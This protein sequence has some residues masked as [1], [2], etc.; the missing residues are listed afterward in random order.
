MRLQ[1]LG[2][3]SCDAAR[4]ELEKAFERFRQDTGVKAKIGKLTCERDGSEMTFKVT[5]NMDTFQQELR[6]GQE[7]RNY[8]DLFGL[9]MGDTL[10]EGSKTF[11]ITGFNPE[12]KF[13]KIIISRQPDGRQFIADGNWARSVKI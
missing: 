6:E 7:M 12:A 13:K 1:H 9:K 8:L 10:R 11:K 5:L 4:A 2:L 3:S